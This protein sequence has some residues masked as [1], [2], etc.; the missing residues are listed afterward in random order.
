MSKI[1]DNLGVMVDMA[2][3]PNSCRHCWLG[4]QKNGKI[5]TNEFRDIAK[6]FKNYRDQSGKGISEIGFFA[7][8]VSRTTAMITANYGI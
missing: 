6:Q 2:G 5:S 4:L 7:G 3:C 1:L 8:G